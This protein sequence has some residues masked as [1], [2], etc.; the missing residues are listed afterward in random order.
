MCDLSLAFL[1]PMVVYWWSFSCGE[2]KEVCESD[3]SLSF[4]VSGDS[5]LECILGNFGK[6]LW[7]WF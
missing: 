7:L 5:A 2:C 1:D 4:V 6:V 3:R